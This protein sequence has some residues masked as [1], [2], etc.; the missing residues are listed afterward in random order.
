MKYKQLTSE[1]RYAI[2]LGL[3][4]KMTLSA[5]AKQIDV[6]VSTISREIKRNKNSRGGYSWRLAHEMALERRERVAYNRLTPRPILKQALNLLV[7]EDWSP[8]QIS[9]YLAKQGVAISHETIYRVIRSD[10][11]GE[12][13]Q[14]CRHRLKYRHHK[15]RKR[16]TKPVSIPNRTSIHQ[17]PLEA[18]GSRFGDW[19][20]DLIL[21]KNQKTAIVTLCERSTNFLIMQRLPFV[22]DSQ[23]LANQVINMLLPYK[24]HILTI[25]T[26]NGSEF[27]KHE[28]IAKKL[29]TD[30]Y[31]TDSYAAWQK[32]AIENTNKLIRQYI[33]KGQDFNMITDDFI[34]QTQYKINRRPRLK[35]NFNSPYKI[36]FS[37]FS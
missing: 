10:T 25:T 33:P 12:L 36:F 4:A 13:V 34:K 29:D 20:M 18:D 5:I 1:Q 6:S 14:H 26:D 15:R 7:T 28:Q 30:I 35:L 37:H 32:G 27:A 23:H 11:S 21:G 8:V 17:R 19:E 3:Q 31:F 24:Q 2:K 9:G 22:K 16:E